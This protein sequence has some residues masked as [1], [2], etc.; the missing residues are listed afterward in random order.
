MFNT[1]YTVC[2]F[3]LKFGVHSIKNMYLNMYKNMCMCV[4]KPENKY[5]EDYT[6]YMYTIT[7]YND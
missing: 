2:T 6:A 3:F 4:Y 7:G 1:F 5:I